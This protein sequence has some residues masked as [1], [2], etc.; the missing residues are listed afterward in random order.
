MEEAVRFAEPRELVGAV[1]V[2]GLTFVQGV[3][4]GG[5]DGLR[6]V[7]ALGPHERGGPGVGDGADQLVRRGR[8]QALVERA[9]VPGGGDVVV[10]A[11]V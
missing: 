7:A 3:Q 5:G 1:H 4:V 9:L 2:K 6:G 8:L 10:A 11:G